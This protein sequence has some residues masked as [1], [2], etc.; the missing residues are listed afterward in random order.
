MVRSINKRID[1][2]IATHHSHSQLD[3]TGSSTA[4]SSAGLDASD[5]HLIGS[6]R[7]SDPS[8]A[9]AASEARR[10]DLK[11]CLKGHHFTGNYT[12][13]SYVDSLNDYRDTI[14]VDAALHPHFAQH[15]SYVRQKLLCLHRPLACPPWIGVTDAIVA[16]DNATTSAR[17]K[18]VPR[19][20][21]TLWTTLP[22]DTPFGVHRFKVKTVH[23]GPNEIYLKL[24]ICLPT[25]SDQPAVPSLATN[26]PTKL[27]DSELDMS[28]IADQ[29]IDLY[30]KILVGL[31]V[32]WQQFHAWLIS[33]DYSWST[34][35]L[36][37]KKAASLCGLLLMLSVQ[38]VFALGEWSLRLLH[39]ARL[40]MVVLMPWLLKLTD[41][42][43]VVIAATFYLFGMMWRDLIGVMF[44]VPQRQAPPMQPMGRI[45]Y[46]DGYQSRQRYQRDRRF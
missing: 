28:P 5:S 10:L 4:S 12:S 2:I 1:S 7:R 45:G 16:T 31:G 6:A 24:R 19:V 30:A 34:F 18:T 43:R 23:F 40:W 27:P 8:T 17:T 20:I 39:E 11:Q 29:L 46:G 15:L 22:P 14:D 37:M 13:K 32:G 9:V 25:A 44:G 3:T 21:W 41:L 38:L 36:V 33:R 42:L 26:L 35:V